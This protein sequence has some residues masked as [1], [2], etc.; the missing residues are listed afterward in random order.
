MLLF[1]FSA[2]SSLSFG[3]RDFGGKIIVQEKKTMTK[4]DDADSCFDLEES[5]F[6]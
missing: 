5:A 1:S 3:V 6:N 2:S 4:D